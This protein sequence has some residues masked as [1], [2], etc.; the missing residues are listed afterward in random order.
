MFLSSRDRYIGELLEFHQGC[1]GPF[2]GSRSKVRFPLRRHSRK[3]PYLAL[4][5][6]LLVFLELGQQTCPSRVTT[7]TS[8]THS[9]GP[10]ESPVSM[11][12]S[13]GFSG[14]L[15]SRCRGR[16]PHLELR[17]ESQGSSSVPTW[18]SGFLCGFHRGVSPHLVWRYASPLS[19]RVVTVVSG[20][21]FS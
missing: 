9:L 20:L 3:G 21:M 18:I 1:Q 16:G 19:S 8:G 11:R 2:Q 10:Q 4:R 14:F 12:G 5:E 15:C 6:N 13:R 7:G 17:P